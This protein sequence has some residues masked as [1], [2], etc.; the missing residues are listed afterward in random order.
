[1]AEQLAAYA[2]SR[3]L[4][5]KLYLMLPQLPEQ[6][7]IAQISLLRGD[8]RL[9]PPKSIHRRQ[10]AAEKSPWMQAIALKAKQRFAGFSEEWNVILGEF[11]FID[12]KV[13]EKKAHQKRFVFRYIFFISMSAQALINN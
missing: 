11:G 12:K 2:S 3:L 9:L 5:K 1:M 10:P 6:R 7:Q 13:I 8:R 4:E